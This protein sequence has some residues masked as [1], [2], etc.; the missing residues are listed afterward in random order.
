MFSWMKYVHLNL[1]EITTHVVFLL[2]NTCL[3]KLNCSRRNIPSNPG[4]KTSFPH[5]TNSRR[6]CVN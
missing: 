5:N 4:N 6:G 2:E 1:D 3:S